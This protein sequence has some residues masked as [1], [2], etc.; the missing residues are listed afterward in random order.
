MQFIHS[1]GLQM[2]NDKQFA[3]QFGFLDK[4]QSVM[5]LIDRR[6]VPLKRFPRQVYIPNKPP[7]VKN[8]GVTCFNI[9]RFR[10]AAG[11]LW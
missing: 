1:D 8:R 3:R 10:D 2:M 6:D 7:V 11:N 5:T 9:W 4:K